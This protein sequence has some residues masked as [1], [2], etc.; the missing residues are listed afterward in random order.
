MTVPVGVPPVAVTVKL[1]V[2]ACPTTEGS[3]GS[4][5]IAVVVLAVVTVC[6]TPSEV[7]PPKLAS[8]A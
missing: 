3:G 6:A 5:V 7:L 1:T 8:P 2:T 4:L